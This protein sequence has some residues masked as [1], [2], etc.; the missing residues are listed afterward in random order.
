MYST[1]QPQVFRQRPGSAGRKDNQSN[2]HL[3]LH[4][5]RSVRNAPKL[6]EG[7]VLR[8]EHARADPQ[9]VQ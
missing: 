8:E 9:G 3:C 6:R 2:F 5:M 4:T 1:Y 7:G